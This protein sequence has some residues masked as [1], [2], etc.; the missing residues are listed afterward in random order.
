MIRYP[1]RHVDCRPA[2]GSVYGFTARHGLRLARYVANAGKREQRLLNVSVDG[3]VSEVKLQAGGFKQQSL[4]T[5]HIGQQ[6]TDAAR[7]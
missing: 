3:L 4:V 2:F 6:F 1:Q 5:G 7:S